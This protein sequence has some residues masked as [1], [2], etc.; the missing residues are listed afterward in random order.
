MHEISNTIDNIN[1]FLEEDFKLE[2][3][4]GLLLE[5]MKDDIKFVNN[6]IYNSINSSTTL[7]ATEIAYQLLKVPMSKLKS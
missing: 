5:I 2:S 6:M 1:E 4:K 3:N 7:S